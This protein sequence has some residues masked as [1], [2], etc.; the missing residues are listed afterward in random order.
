MEPVR[1]ARPGGSKALGCLVYG[2]LTLVLG[3]AAGLVGLGLA[4]WAA[5]SAKLSET[6]QMV[7]GGAA[8]LALFALVAWFGWRDFRRR[9]NVEVL[10]K[11]DALVLNGVELA[12]ADVETVHLTFDGRLPTIVLETADG[13]RR[14]PAEIAP[15]ERVEPLLVERLLPRML[16]RFEK[17]LAAGRT[18]PLRESGARAVG[19]VLYGVFLLL[20]APLMILLVKFQGFDALRLGV[21]RI[22]QGWRGRGGGF[23]IAADG[24]LPPGEEA[25]ALPWR[26]LAAESLD[27]HGVTLVSMEG[28][29]VSAS[30]FAPN[31]WPLSRLIAARLK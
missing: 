23:T 18:V 9:A 12:F 4:A 8:G 25:R 2:V 14:L 15:F 3:L 24:V 11:A 29:R 16:E 6:L 17:E 19:R 30:R 7:A 27:A 20:L 5:E 31:F 13:R 26:E 10:V 1:F 22:R 28:P 21:A